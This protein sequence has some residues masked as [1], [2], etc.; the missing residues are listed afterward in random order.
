MAKSLVTHQNSKIVIT[1]YTDAMENGT[2]NV[3]LSEFRANIVKSFLLGLG[4]QSYQMRIQG[5]GGQ[6]P[7]E[8]NDTVWGRMMNRRVEIEM[9]N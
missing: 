9:I 7:V 4:V 5:R 3:K 8:S 2:Y 6:D 1:G